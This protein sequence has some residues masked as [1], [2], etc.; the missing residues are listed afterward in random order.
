MSNSIQQ[1]FRTY[2][3]AYVE[4]FGEH[5]PV[6]HK[7]VIQA[8]C[9][10]G[11]GLC[12]THSFSCDGCGKLHSADGSCGNRHCPT[13]QTGK[14][15][16]WLKKMEAKTLP[17]NYF[18]VTFTVPQEL[19]ELIRSNQKV[20]Y[21][22]LFKAAADAMKKLAKDPR[23]VGCDTSG[24]TGI[25]HTW[26][27]QFI[28]HPHVH[29]IVPGGGLSKDGAEWKPS[30]EEFFIHA[31]PL[32]KIYRAKFIGL[33]EK[34]GLVVPP[35]VWDT[36]WVVDCRNVG[37][38]KKA[39]K[40]IAQYVFRVAIAP[41]R[42]LTVT[43]TEVLFKY[44]PSGS[45]GWKKMSLKIFEFMRRYLQHTLPRGFTKVRHFGFMASNAKVPLARIRELICALYEILIKLLP[46][47]QA[48]R[49]K[50]WVCKSCGGLIRWRAFIPCPRGTG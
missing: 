45:K 19:R 20:C 48:A 3:P 46:K 26:S 47:K 9:N 22:A 11:T 6:N 5:M 40:Y 42:I 21:A 29:F 27:R 13:C 35:C 37:N 31:K 15:D 17:A 16:E 14:S 10:C 8:I 25:L 7:K 4:R 23:F 41:S 18:M 24:F 50:P 49:K 38:G 33:L 36:D 28:Y 12:G 39:L 30:G 2:G 1:L 43:E 34:E 44:K 32:S